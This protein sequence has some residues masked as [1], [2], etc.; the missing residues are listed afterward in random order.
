MSIPTHEKAVIIGISGPS[1]SGKT[2][3]ARL[4][5]RIFCGVNLKPKDSPLNTFI[6]HEDDFYFPDDQI[7]YTTTASGTKIQDW[8]T[9]AAIDIPFLSQALHYVRENGRLPPRLQSKEDQ[10][11]ETSSGVPDEIVQELRDVV[12]SRLRDGTAGKSTES[13]TIAFLEGFL[14]FAPP[15]SKSEQEQHVL[16]SVHDAINLHLFLPAAYELVKARREGRSGYVTVGPA[17]EPPV[18]TT[19]DGGDGKTR[20]EIDL[21]AE[22]DRPPQN[23][24]VDPPGY[25]DD[26]VW[27]R[28]VADHAW[29]LISDDEDEDK[30]GGSQALAEAD[31][32]R[33]VGDGTRARTDVG[34]EVAPGCGSAGMDVVLRWAVELILGYYLDRT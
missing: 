28:Y 16:R 12:G 7:P 3:L 22:D 19:E 15:Q 8:D 30:K 21:E 18:Q 32:V 31:L 25:V 23:F 24:W 33:R 27:P 20:T 6:I 10:N 14:L 34:V 13:P 17:P 11:D 9:A 4:L 29:L 2:T 5:Q 26:V 1:S